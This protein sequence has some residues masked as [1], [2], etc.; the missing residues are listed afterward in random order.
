MII[1]TGSIAYDYILDFPGKYSDHILPDQIHKLNLSFIATKFDKKYGGTAANA[2]Y[3]LGLLKTPNKLF[4]SAGKD[5]IEYKNHLKKNGVD[6]SAVQVDKEKYTALGFA[7][8]DKTDNQIWGYFYGAADNNK[9]LILKNVANKGDLVLVG[10]TGADATMRM[11]KQC[12]ELKIDYM[13]DPGFIL[14]DVTPDQLRLGIKRAK[15][16]IG[17]DYEI[18][19]IRQR[20]ND[21]KTYFKD[22]VV[23]TTLGKEGAVIETPKE[24]ITIKPA[25]VKKVIDPTGAG[26]AWRG[27]FLA[28]LDRGFDLKTCGQMGSL[29]ASFA[30]E[31]YGTQEYSYTLSDFQNRYRQTFNS[32]LKL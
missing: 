24:K 17:N 25:V 23:I 31:V 8:T 10:P 21:W 1:I 32:L 30:V 19:S 12:V 22:K 2:A 7:I 13:F 6:C 5:F 9:N 4:S 14:T 18:E 20:V 27:G 3:C 11:V 29:A 15:Y 16:I 28:G 26:D